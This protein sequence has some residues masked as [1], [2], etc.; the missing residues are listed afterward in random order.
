MS[1]S[2]VVQSQPTSSFPPPPSTSTAPLQFVASE[3]S[4]GS[5][6]SAA[7][8]TLESLAAAIIDI[9]RNIASMQA[10]WAGLVQQPSPPAVLDAA[11]VHGAGRILRRRAHLHAARHTSLGYAGPVLRSSAR[12]HHRHSHCGAL[13]CAAACTFHRRLR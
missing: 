6:M 7:P 13:A 1:T 10:A 5:T 4:E 12:V 11:A 2:L 8:L 3:V 9:N